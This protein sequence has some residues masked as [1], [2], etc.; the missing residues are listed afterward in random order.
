MTERS[1]YYEILGVEPTATRS[2]IEAAYD[3]LARRYQPDV[4]KEPEEPEKMRVLDE[5]F[6]T[7][8]DPIRRAAYHR[9]RGLPEPPSEPPPAP[10]PE[11]RPITDRRTLGAIALIVVS[12]GAVIAAIVLGVIAL[13]DEGPA[14]V[15]LPSGLKFRDIVEGAGP[16]PQP[17]QTVTVH[18]TG[19][20]EDGTVFDTSVGGQPFSFVLGEGEVI[21]GWEEGLASMRLGSARELI[22]P[23]ELAYGEEGTETI[24]PNET[25][26]FEVHLLAVN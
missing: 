21:E 17:G 26:T 12:A 11:A 8:D 4:S 20:L 14:Y 1:D 22:I 10:R 15:T 16:Y 2:E 13:L 6:D 5:A 9:E 7:L 18:Y 23:P 25:L 3:R 24:P 19:Y